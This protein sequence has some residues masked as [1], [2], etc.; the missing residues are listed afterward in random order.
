LFHTSKRE[1]LLCRA[2]IHNG[3]GVP[4]E[5]FNGINAGILS[6]RYGLGTVDSRHLEA[7]GAARRAYVAAL[8]ERRTING[9]FAAKIQRG[10]FRQYFKS[11]ESLELF[12]DAQVI[13]LYREDLLAQ[14]IS[15]H[16]SLLTGRWGVD[17]TVTTRPVAD[18]QFFDNDLIAKHLEELATQDREW[19]L[20][21]ANNAIRPLFLSYEGIKDDLAGALRKIVTSFGL[22][23]PSQ[24]FTYVERSPIDFSAPGEPSKSEIRD[25]FLRAVRGCRAAG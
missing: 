19:R 2:L 7:G 24:D 3:I 4:H 22:H 1:H 15:L 8:L 21:F 25:R 12:Q 13:Y 11:T 23:L 6:S 18:P 16:L 10:Q 9:I 20:F 14:A 5:Y 17:D